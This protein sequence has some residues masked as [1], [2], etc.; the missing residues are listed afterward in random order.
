MPF[1]FDEP[2]LSGAGASYIIIIIHLT[3]SSLISTDGSIED[4]VRSGVSLW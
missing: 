4:L 1:M 2:I 3:P